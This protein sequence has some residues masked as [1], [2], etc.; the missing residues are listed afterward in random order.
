MNAHSQ[1]TDGRR[2]TILRASG[3]LV[4]A[5]LGVAIFP[6]TGLAPADAEGTS[7]GFSIAWAP[8]PE[9]PPVQCGSLT[10][11]VDWSQ[12]FKERISVAVA[13]RPADDREHRI[14]TV[15][16][17]PGGPGD[18]GVRYVESAEAV[19]SRT[20]LSRF[21]LVAMDP[22]GIGGSTSITCTTPVLTPELTLFPS[23]REAFGQLKQHNRT[24][25]Q[26]CLEGTGPLIKHADT[27]QRREGP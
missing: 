5:G 19:F 11:P 20:L 15:F 21:D 9:A 17:N 4:A 1:S 2:V 16:F 27:R 23:T 26:S 22:R 14:G 24:V 10:V 18:G 3:L 6:T 8:C 25:A 13:R 12:P 7:S